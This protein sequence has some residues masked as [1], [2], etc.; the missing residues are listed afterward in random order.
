M[1]FSKLRSDIISA[2]H[3]PFT[4]HMGTHLWKVNT[5]SLKKKKNL[6]I[7]IQNS[8]KEGSECQIAMKFMKPVTPKKW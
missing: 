3:L 8:K 1:V 5:C 7:A 6:A 4:F 2:G